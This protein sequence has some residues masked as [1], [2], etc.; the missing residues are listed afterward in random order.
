MTSFNESFN[1]SSLSFNQSSLSF[2]QS[3]FA[4][5]A[6]GEMPTH[7]LNGMTPKKGSKK[8]VKKGSF[9]G[10]QKGVQKGP[11]FGVHFRGP[12]ERPKFPR[13]GNPENP[14]EIPRARKMCI[15]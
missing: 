8:G 6:H 9:L 4:L 1:Q 15:F 11:F 5:H 7:S 3:S 12:A 2:N 14:P 13:P 10:V